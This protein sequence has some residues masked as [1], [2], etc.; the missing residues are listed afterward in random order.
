MWYDSTTQPYTEMSA[1]MKTLGIVIGVLFVAAISFIIG[2]GAGGASTHPTVVAQAP[3]A[4]SV[5]APQPI[6]APPTAEPAGTTHPY[7]AFSDGTYE[8]GT[9]DGQILPG[10]YTVGAAAGP[11]GNYYEISQG[12]QIIK[13]DYTHGP[14]FMT[15]AK[16]QTVKVSG[17]GLWTANS[18]W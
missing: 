18:G 11:M 12:G 9:G 2:V 8:V 6:P 7:V 13:N 15:V 10:K 14:T 17:G 1:A 3:V 16:G 5:P 4:Q